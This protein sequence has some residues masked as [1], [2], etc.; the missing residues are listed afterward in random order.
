MV[1]A[2]VLRT[3]A[4][5]VG[6]VEKWKSRWFCEISK[7]VGE[8]AETRFW[9]LPASTLLPFLPRR[10]AFRGGSVTSGSGHKVKVSLDATAQ[11][12]TID[13]TTGNPTTVEARTEPSPD[14]PPVPQRIYRITNSDVIQTVT[15][16][17]VVVFPDPTTPANVLPSRFTL[18]A[19]Y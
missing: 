17:G 18:V 13:R 14:A 4:A 15:L 2:F 3:E 8:P 7:G 16:N 9:F 19:I 6:A 10:D 11:V 5:V 1:L 12:L